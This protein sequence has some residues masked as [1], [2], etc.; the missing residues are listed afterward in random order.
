MITMFEHYDHGGLLGNPLML[1][2]ILGREPR[3][4]HAYFEELAEHRVAGG[5]GPGPS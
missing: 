5:Q 1:T 4:L 3:T 2:T